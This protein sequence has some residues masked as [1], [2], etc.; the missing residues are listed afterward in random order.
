MESSSSPTSSSSTNENAALELQM[1]KVAYSWWHDIVSEG[2]NGHGTWCHI[3]GTVMAIREI[4]SVKNLDFK[5]VAIDIQ[6]RDGSHP[7]LTEDM[8]FKFQK[9]VKPGDT[10]LAMCREAHYAKGDS[11]MKSYDLR[12]LILVSRGTLKS[13][14]VQLFS[15]DSYESPSK[16]LSKKK[17]VD[18]RKDAAD[19]Q[20][21]I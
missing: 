21:R 11:V 1:D 16:K 9:V 2:S 7:C 10:V 15:C 8:D 12:Q 17:K 13:K 14:R 3:Y 5:R 20:E 19:T 18:K 4:G 6:N